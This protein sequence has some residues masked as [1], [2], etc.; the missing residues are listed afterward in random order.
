M[1][2]G[3]LPSTRTCD[4]ST[5][6]SRASLPASD[7]RLS[8]TLRLFLFSALKRTLWPATN[9]VDQ[10]RLPTHVITASRL[11]DL[12]HVGAHVGEQKGAESAGQKA[13]EVEH[14]DPIQ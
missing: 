14:A 5:R 7:L 1:T 2:P 8:V 4:R 11:L 6:P 13:R 10:W 3:L 9:A 12:D